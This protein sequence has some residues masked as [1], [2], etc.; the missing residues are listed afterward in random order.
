MD[1]SIIPALA[2]LTGAA[3]G[4]LTSGI[5]S[6]FAQ[7]TQSRVQ[8]LAQDKVVREE[9]YKEFI[10]AATQCYTDALQHEKPD[11]PALVSLYGTIGRM[12]VL[13]SPRVL[14][15]AEQ[16]GQKIINMYLEPNKTFFELREMINK[17]A[18]DILDKFGEACR[19]EFRS[20]HMR[21]V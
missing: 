4:G 2:G 8:L 5:T 12:R 13:S 20:L 21:T 17:N 18:I 10:E 7:K 1:I 3:I 6:W 19:E 15:S 16:I 11:I 14:A 9:L